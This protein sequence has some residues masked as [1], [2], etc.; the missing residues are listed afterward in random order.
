MFK[1]IRT[2][3]AVTVALSLFTGVAQAAVVELAVNGGFETGDFSGWTQFP[4][5]G[6]Q[7]ISTVNPSSGTYSGNI[8]VA[9]APINT[10]LKQANLAAGLLM[11]GQS[12]DIT[13][14][15][16]GTLLDGGVLFM[17]N[18][19]ELSGG[20]VSNNDLRVIGVNADSNIWTSY[21]INTVLGPDVSGGYTLQFAA[22]C[23]AATSCLADVFLDN[24]SITADVNA[25]PVPAAVWL[26]GS[27]LVG[28]VGIARKRKSV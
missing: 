5:S 7:T 17:E 1:K 27:G 13:F 4:G 26:F 15:V 2:A 23:G 16:R 9:A 14:D 25:V 12:V 3:S 11:P 22:V 8:S 18:F 20:G 6:T 10:V 19:S 28:L 24:I 21:A